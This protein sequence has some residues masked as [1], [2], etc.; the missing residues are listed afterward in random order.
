MRELDLRKLGI[1]VF[2]F[3]KSV[4]NRCYDRNCVTPLQTEAHGWTNGKQHT[5]I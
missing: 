4:G 1:Y 5:R 2:P 3:L